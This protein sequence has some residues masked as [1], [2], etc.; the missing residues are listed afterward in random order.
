MSM[1]QSKYP[2]I[3]TL[4][5]TARVLLVDWYKEVSYPEKH[6]K[7][8]KGCCLQLVPA[9][10][11]RNG[12]VKMQ[13]KWGLI[14][15]MYT[16]IMWVWLTVYIIIDLLSHITVLYCSALA[17][18]HYSVN[19]NLSQFFVD[20]NFVLHSAQNLIFGMEAKKKSATLQRQ[21]WMW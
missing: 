18:A 10:C 5:F 17:P 3:L 14:H 13:G 21:R 15:Y 8:S 6:R 1:K 9:Y 7:G 2:R 4:R 16:V 20:S 11:S 19:H 12:F